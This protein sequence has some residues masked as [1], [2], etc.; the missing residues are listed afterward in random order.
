MK[1]LQSK[2]VGGQL[3]RRASGVAGLPVSWYWLAPGCCS[4]HDKAVADATLH[5]GCVG[6]G[7]GGVVGQA[8]VKGGAAV[9]A[10]AELVKAQGSGRLDARLAEMWACGRGGRCSVAVR[11]SSRGRLRRRLRRRT[12]TR[13]DNELTYSR[14]TGSITERRRVGAPPRRDPQPPP[15]PP[16]PASPDTTPTARPAHH[17]CAWSDVTFQTVTLGLGG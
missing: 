13:P 5:F 1:A 6:G 10:E 15:A 14:P 17:W 11:A 16:I 3:A 12:H 8:R 7:R 9:G 2:C 4:V